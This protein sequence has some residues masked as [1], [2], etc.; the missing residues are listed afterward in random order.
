MFWIKYGWFLWATLRFLIYYI[1]LLT[2]QNLAKPLKYLLK[3]NYWTNWFYTN[4]LS[5]LLISV[6]THAPLLMYTQHHWE[7]WWRT[8]HRD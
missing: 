8:F 6:I 7:I 3:K 1:L 2:N 4:S 5:K